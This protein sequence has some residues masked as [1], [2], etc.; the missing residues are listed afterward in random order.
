MIRKLVSSDSGSILQVVNDA[1]RAYDGVIPADRWKEPYM[2]PDELREELESGVTFYG[3]VENDQILGVM[4]IQRVKDATLIR[5]SYV[6]TECQGKG[7]GGKLLD[8]LKALTDAPELMVGTWEDAAWAISFYE[9]HGFQLVSCRE[10]NRLL[11]EYWNI[12]ER[13]IETSVV[14]RFKKARIRAS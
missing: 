8:F 13:Q 5:H 2:S 4:G 1:A 11:R 12:P 7:I 3:W 14:L 10:K 9:R 6:L